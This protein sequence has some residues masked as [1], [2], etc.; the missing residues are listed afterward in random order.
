MCRS[1]ARSFLFFVLLVASTKARSLSP[2]V[3]IGFP[4]AIYSMFSTMT[5]ISISLLAKGGQA[6]TQRP[7]AQGLITALLELPGMGGAVLFLGA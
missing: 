6:P 4:L 5:F 3:G 7:D 2:R 1:S